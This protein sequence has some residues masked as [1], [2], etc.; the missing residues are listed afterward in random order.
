MDYTVVKRDGFRVIGKVMQVSIRAGEDERQIPEFWNECNQNG[1]CVK[2]CSMTE[3]KD[4]LGICIDMDHEKELFT[5][6]VAVEDTYNT[7]ESDFISR[8]IPAANWAVFPLIGPV[9]E[10]IRELWETIFREWFPTSGY[11]HGKAPQME[12]YPPG[13][14]NSEDYRCE[15]WIP[16]VKK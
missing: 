15:I 8:D 2:L 6:M 14:P 3:K 7:K 16:V 1:I 11:V 9:A 12:V 13:N 5:Y 10:G 4:L